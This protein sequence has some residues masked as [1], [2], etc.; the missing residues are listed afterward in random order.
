MHAARVT[1][2]VDERADAL[3]GRQRIEDDAHPV[4]RRPA[5]G[6]HAHGRARHWHGVSGAAHD[7]RIRAQRARVSAPESAR[8]KSEPLGEASGQVVLG[9]PHDLE[10]RDEGSG[11][12][13]E[14]HP[15]RVTR[16][17][18]G[19]LLGHQGRGAQSEE[20]GAGG[21]P[22]RRHGVEKPPCRLQG[23]GHVADESTVMLARHDAVEA[24][25]DRQPAL[26]Q[27]LFHHRVGA[28]AGV[29]VEAQGDRSGRQGWGHVH[30]PTVT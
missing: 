3:G 25:L 13:P 27:E 9:E 23:V 21:G 29:R 15:T 20:E 18:P 4:S 8:Q 24:G 1:V 7:G 11:S 14:A 30:R 22:T 6:G 10:V 28:E 16:R 2:G 26:G 19:H 5:D 17:Q 12:Q